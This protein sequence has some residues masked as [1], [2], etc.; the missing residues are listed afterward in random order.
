MFDL[1]LCVLTSSKSSRLRGFEKIGYTKPLKN[2]IRIVYLVDQ[3]DPKPDYIKE[4]WIG[5]KDT[6]LSCRFLRYIAEHQDDSRW[7]LQ[8][9]DDSATDI[10]KTIELID[11][12]YDYKEP[13]V[14]K[15]PTFYIVDGNVH[16]TVY[17]ENPLQN[18]LRK[19]KIEN[20][21]MG[22]ED[23]NTFSLASYFD[24][25]WEQSIF[26]QEA[27]KKCKSYRRIKELTDL[28]VEAKPQFGDQVPY[29]LAK[30]AKIPVSNC[31]FL[32][33]LPEA[34]QY[35]ALNK[36]GRY[37]HIHH[38]VDYWEEFSNFCS[39]LENR[40]QYDSEKEV[41]QRLKN[42]DLKNTFW[43]FYGISRGETKHYGIIKLSEDG[44]IGLYQNGNERFWQQK[45]NNIVFLDQENKE[46]SVLNKISDARYEG[47]HSFIAGVRH[48]IEK[49]DIKTIIR[50][51]EGLRL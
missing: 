28:C 22:T 11:Q 45:N 6:P 13:V 20:I 49:I 43:N 17:M 37:T 30:L 4:E 41:A 8:V 9:D 14:L 51:K 3:E 40:E 26:S 5:F 42:K 15:G 25:A 44:T 7:V 27:I 39:M 10:D 23:L 33:P 38:V 18:V 47:Q 32:C 2:K 12:F 35:T 36:N 16:V 1:T 46:S 19:M 50:I 48:F 29:V 31:S 21:F 24:H 34:T